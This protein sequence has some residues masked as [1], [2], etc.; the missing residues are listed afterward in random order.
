M[1]APEYLSDISSDD[2]L[3]AAPWEVI[4]DEDEV[5]EML[6]M[7]E[8]LWSEQNISYTSGQI[9]AIPDCV[10]G[11]YNY[12]KTFNFDSWE[13]AKYLVFGVNQLDV[14]INKWYMHKMNPF[15]NFRVHG[16]VCRVNNRNYCSNCAMLTIN[17]EGFLVASVEQE[18]H[19]WFTSSEIFS[20]VI[21][22][23]ETHF[24]CATCKSFLY[25]LS[26]SIDCVVCEHVTVIND[27]S[28]Y[29]N[30]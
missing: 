2:E 12:I 17:D 9:M 14:I 10:L 21:R 16:T 30:F 11:Q 22:Y 3:A 6:S 24:F 20:S 27:V 18:Y 1:C 23:N 19:G 7:E 8:L 26:D 13:V 28:L 5:Q 25:E 15:E 29:S 4:P